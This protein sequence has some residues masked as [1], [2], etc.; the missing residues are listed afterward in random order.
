MKQFHLRALSLFLSAILVLFSGGCGKAP[1]NIPVSPF[2]DAD[3]TCTAEDILSFEGDDFTTY[4]SVYGGLCYTYPKV[5]EDHQGTIKY[6]LDEEGQLKCIAFTFSAEEE[7][8]LYSFYELVEESVNA[9]IPFETDKAA[10]SG[11]IWYRQEGNI[12]LSLMIT[13]D[14][15]ALQ[16]SYLH[17]DVSSKAGD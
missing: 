2:S 8:E 14:L 17:P 6:M 12:I 9:K 15:K 1:A 16:Y 10:N 5:Y 4:D 7:Q 3:W 13:S 11:H